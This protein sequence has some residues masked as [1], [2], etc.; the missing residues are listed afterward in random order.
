[1]FAFAALPAPWNAL[2]QLVLV[3]IAV[4]L[5]GGFVLN[6]YDTGR[7]GRMPKATQLPQSFALIGVALVVWLAAAR[8]TPLNSMALFF[9]L[10]IACGFLGDLFMANVFNQEQHVLFGMAAFALGHVFYMLGFR[11]IALHFG[12]HDLG[13]YAL[14]LVLM[15][16]LALVIWFALIRRPEGDAMQYAALAYALFLASMAGYALGLALQ[17]GA[18]WPLAVGAILF[19]LS[20]TLIGARLFAG[21]RFAYSGDVIWTTYIAAQVLIVTAAPAALAL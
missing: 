20:D 10:G 19:L 6:A 12:Y 11:E 9:A 18:F 3:G 1:M 8:E 21:Q 7:D 17:Q 14:G 13:R 4:L 5:V 2:C 15:W 16:A